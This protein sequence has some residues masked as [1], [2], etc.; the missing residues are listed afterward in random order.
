MHALKTSLLAALLCHPALAVADGLQLNGKAVHGGQSGGFQLLPDGEQGYG[1]VGV[2]LELPDSDAL[3]AVTLEG[4]FLEDGALLLHGLGSTGDG[5][6]LYV[7]EADCAPDGGTAECSGALH[8][9]SDADGRKSGSIVLR[10]DDDASVSVWSLAYDSLGRGVDEDEEHQV[11]VR[12]TQDADFEAWDTSIVGSDLGRALFDR[13]S[14]SLFVFEASCQGEESTM[15]SASCRPRGEGYACG[16]LALAP[17][18]VFLD[19]ADPD[20]LGPV[21]FALRMSL[22]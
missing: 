21:L 7:L 15:V 14:G 3:H 22:Y 11:T 19:A 20:D 16:G 17:A 12:L 4:A 1:K 9:V 6:V 13:N 5:L 18:G 10:G 2:S 8:A